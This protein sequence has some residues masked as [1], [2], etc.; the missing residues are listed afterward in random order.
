MRRAA[1]VSA[2]KEHF[3]EAEGTEISQQA[4]L[5]VLHLDQTQKVQATNAMKE[6][7]PNCLVART[8]KSDG[9]QKVTVYKNVAKINRLHCQWKSHL[10]HW[11]RHPKSQILNG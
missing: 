4:V 5:E 1:F 3:W 9:K 10:C 2:L 6:V 8:R 7:F 11:M